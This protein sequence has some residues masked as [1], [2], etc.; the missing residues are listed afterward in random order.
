MT[1]HKYNS[2]AYFHVQR[3]SAAPLTVSKYNTLKDEGGEIEEK[4][5]GGVIHFCQMATDLLSLTIKVTKQ[6]KLLC[7]SNTK[8]DTVLS[9]L[10]ISPSI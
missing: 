7:H 8:I 3:I 1:S 9:L 5:K 6:S 2:N 4:E 10:C